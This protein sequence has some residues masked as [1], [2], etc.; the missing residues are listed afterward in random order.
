MPNPKNEAEIKVISEKIKKSKIMILTHYRGLNVGQ[1]TAIRKKVR[2]SGG[3]YKVLKKTL[4]RIAL[5]QCN[6]SEKLE[7]PPGPT[8]LVFGYEDVVAASKAIFEFSN[9]F[10]KLVIKHGL[11]GVDKKLSEQDIR[12]LAKLPN[13]EVLLA[14]VVGQIKAPIS[15][16]VYTL[17]GVLN[18][19]VYALEAIK[20]KKPATVEKVVK[21]AA[22]DKVE[23][24]KAEVKTTE[25]KPEV[26]TEE[27]KSEVKTEES[28]PE[29]KPEESKP[30][31]KAE[32]NK[33]EP[34]KEVK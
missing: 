20:N 16:L 6:L 22:P 19:L 33:E 25:S 28:K 26:K 4:T 15:G 29:V 11:L 8:A 23:E 32:D 9:E 27:I 12:A 17:K 5:Q 21:D 24:K 30:E 1:V 2:E 10:D 31:V 3:E 18:K 13:R 34:N 7:I 14:Q